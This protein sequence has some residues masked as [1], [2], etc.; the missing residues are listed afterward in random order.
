ML[1]T[2]DTEYGKEYWDT[3]DGGMGY[4]DSMLWVNISCAVKDL[5]GID[6]VAQED[7]SPGMKL[8][9]VGCAMG[10]SVRWFRKQGFDAWG[11]DLSQYALDHAPEDI[12]EY[13]RQFDLTSPHYGWS[14]GDEQFQ[15]V[16]CFETME[17]IPDQDDGWGNNTI[18]TALRHIKEALVSG[19]HALFTICTEDQPGWDTDPTHVTIKS[20][21]WWVKRLQA[22][23]FELE[24]ESVAFLRNFWLFANH[25]GVLVVKKP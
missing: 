12:A 16:T 19:G 15:V 24:E 7:I 21:H 6:R 13:L 4:Q 22:A 2:D 8:L 20:R 14:F 11:V 25:H 18:D 23:G 1:R 5:F 3:L 10:Y 9:D 17:H